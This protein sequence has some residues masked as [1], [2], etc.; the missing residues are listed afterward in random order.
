MVVL[1][2]EDADVEVVGVVFL[3][4]YILFLWKGKMSRST[5][6]FFRMVMMVLMEEQ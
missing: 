6:T 2:D 3:V 1:V 5:S 4:E